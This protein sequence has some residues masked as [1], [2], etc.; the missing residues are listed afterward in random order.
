MI[1]SICCGVLVTAE[2]RLVTDTG[3][4]W[5]LVRQYVHVWLSLVRPSGC[6][7]VEVAGADGLDGFTG[8]GIAEWIEVGNWVV[9][10][11]AEV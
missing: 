10:V 5:P 2:I 6:S 3:N 4:W 8:V 9:E 1:A 7:H 11:G